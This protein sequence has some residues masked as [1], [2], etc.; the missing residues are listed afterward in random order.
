M[1]TLEMPPEANTPRDPHSLEPWEHE[2]LS[3]IMRHMREAYTANAKGLCAELKS[4]DPA[5]IDHT[6]RRVAE[7][8]SI[9]VL[10]SRLAAWHQK[11]SENNGEDQ[12][13]VQ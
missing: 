11:Q 9:A 13:R 1:S 8:M 10:C 5:F 3:R 4:S 7:Q 12:C 2:G 6:M